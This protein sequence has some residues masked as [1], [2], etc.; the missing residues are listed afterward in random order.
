M[1]FK[2]NIKKELNNANFNPHSPIPLY[3]QA[4]SFIRN[5]IIKGI[6]KHG[7]LLPPEIELA[8]SLNIGRQTLRQAMSQLVE[9]GLVERFS[10]RGTFVCEKN[11][12]KEFFL[13]RSFSQEMVEL[14]K[15][16]HSRVLNISN[17]VID[18]R[19]PIFFLKKLGAPCLYLTRLRYGDEIPIGLQEAIILTERCPDLDKHDFT[20]ESLF[21]VIT[22]IYGFE[23]SEIYH[24]V[25]AV[26][27][28]KAHAK[29]LEIKTGS[30]LLLEKSV[31]FLSD[32]EP[33][34]AATSYFRA[35]QYEYSVRFRY[36]GSKSNKYSLPKK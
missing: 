21:R 32:G 31:T 20:K 24:I 26:I 9:E 33:I 28:T 25:N 15:K 30:P 18:E 19:A 29:L 8:H 6:F 34:E 10:G 27:A 2:K 5:M 12:K 7:D 1:N 35:D 17:G 13:D 11:P 3:H 4:Y 23:I 16:T 14:G 22:E 36:M